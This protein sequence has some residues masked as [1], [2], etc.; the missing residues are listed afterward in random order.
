MKTTQIKNTEKLK[1]NRCV[2]YQNYVRILKKIK[3]NK[4]NHQAKKTKQNQLKKEC[5]FFKNYL[6][7]IKVTFSRKV[8]FSKQTKIKKKLRI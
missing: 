2:N 3:K 6:I 7:K 8:I 1:Q 5:L 4:T